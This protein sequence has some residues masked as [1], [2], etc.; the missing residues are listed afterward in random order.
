M[1]ITIVDKDPKS[2]A[3][4]RRGRRSRLRKPVGSAELRGLIDR[5]NRLFKEAQKNPD[6]EAGDMV[7]MFLLSGMLAD[8][9]GESCARLADRRRRAQLEFIVR[10]QRARLDRIARAAQEAKAQQWDETAIYNKIASIVG[11]GRP[12]KM[13]HAS[14]QD[15]QQVAGAQR[16]DTCQT[17][18]SQ[19]PAQPSPITK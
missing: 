12:L 14:E 6:S 10:E 19:T 9:A 2:R 13:Y 5:R 18:P 15:Q 7:Q 8:A 4:R 17:Q 1:S 16:E 11:L 3:T